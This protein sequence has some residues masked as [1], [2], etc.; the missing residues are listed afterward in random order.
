MGGL[1]WDNGRYGA[2]VD[3]KTTMVVVIAYV[4]CLMFDGA[5]KIIVSKYLDGITSDLNIL[6][7]I[8]TFSEPPLFFLQLVSHELPADLVLVN[9]C[10]PIIFDVFL[11][12]GLHDLLGHLVHFLQNI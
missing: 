7:C 11:Y 6:H 8:N 4:I 3:A 10:H 9:P 2:H 12:F 1:G 5:Q